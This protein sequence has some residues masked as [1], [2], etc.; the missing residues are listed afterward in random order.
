MNRSLSDFSFS[1]VMETKSGSFIL[2]SCGCCNLI[3][4]DRGRHNMLRRSETVLILS[5]CVCAL[6]FLKWS[7]LLGTEIS[8]LSDLSL[9]FEVLETEDTSDGQDTDDIFF[10]RLAAFFFWILL[11]GSAPVCFVMHPCDDVNMRSDNKIELLKLLKD[12]SGS[13]FS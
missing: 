6:L 12:C 1:G 4:L 10:F 9:L 5:L 11:A 2:Y 7:S 8:L 13:E 3:Y